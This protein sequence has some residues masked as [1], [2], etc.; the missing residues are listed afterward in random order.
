MRSNY[1][2]SRE[3]QKKAYRRHLIKAYAPLLVVLVLVVV[4]ALL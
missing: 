2:Y 1:W 3:M 4:V